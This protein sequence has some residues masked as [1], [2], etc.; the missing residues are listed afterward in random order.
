MLHKRGENRES[1]NGG[2]MSLPTVVGRITEKNLSLP[3][4]VGRITE[5]I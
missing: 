2:S 3:T 1:I 5:K 4:V